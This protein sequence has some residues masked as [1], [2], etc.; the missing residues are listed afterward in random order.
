MGPRL[1]AVGAGSSDIVIVSMSSKSSKGEL[2]IRHGFYLYDSCLIFN[3]VKFLFTFC[4][5]FVFFVKVKLYTFCNINH[6][7][8]S[9]HLS[10]MFIS[11]FMYRYLLRQS[12]VYVLIL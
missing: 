8:L 4:C 7:N 9:F 6:V 10:I 5:Y 3:S 1:L 2:N 11:D 12:I